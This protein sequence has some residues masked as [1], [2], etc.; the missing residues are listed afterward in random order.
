MRFHR[1]NRFHVELEARPLL[2]SNVPPP[3]HFRSRNPLES[4]ARAPLF[5][6]VGESPLRSFDDV[7]HES[8]NDAQRARAT[9][10]LVKMYDTHSRRNAMHQSARKFHRREQ[11]G[12][13]DKMNAR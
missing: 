13:G 9:L 12:R 3:E 6:E 11:T 10:R 8:I 1:I 5:I 2:A 4:L 7:S